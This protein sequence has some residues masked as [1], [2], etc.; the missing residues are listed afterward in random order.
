[1]YAGEVYGCSLRVGDWLLQCQD[2]LLSFSRNM[3]PRRSQKLSRLCFTPS[4]VA[5]GY[6][7]CSN[8]MSPSIVPT[9]KISESCCRNSGI[10]CNLF[11]ML[12]KYSKY[13]YAF[14]I[15]HSLIVYSSHHGIQLYKE[16]SFVP[17]FC[18]NK[19]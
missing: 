6:H 5:I 9:L 8:T 19:I 2:H 11:H 3:E 15:T 16:H 17:I 4:S 18:C 10:T 13:N 14:Y 12:P 7:F 1:M